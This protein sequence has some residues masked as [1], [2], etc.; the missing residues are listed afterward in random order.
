MRIKYKPCSKQMKMVSF[1]TLYVPCQSHEIDSSM[2]RENDFNKN[3]HDEHC[4]LYFLLKIPTNQILW[5]HFL[6]FVALFT[7]ISA[8]VK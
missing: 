3:Q 8:N 7:D 2:C 1:F 6:R 4:V 5:I